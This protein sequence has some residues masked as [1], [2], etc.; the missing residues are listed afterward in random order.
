MFHFFQ[1][2]PEGAVCVEDVG[3]MSN[4]GCG[5]YTKM[6]GVST[7]P[8]SRCTTRRRVHARRGLD[9]GQLTPRWYL[10]ALHDGGNYQQAPYQQITEK[11]FEAGSFRRS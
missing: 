4:S 9:V 6:S 11:Q 3:A 10:A 2:A 7:S 1:K 5:S 8:A